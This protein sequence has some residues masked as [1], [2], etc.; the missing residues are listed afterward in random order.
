M[1][2]YVVQVAIF[3]ATYTFLVDSCGNCE[4]P[5]VGAGLLALLAAFLPSVIWVGM[6]DLSLAIRKHRKVARQ[7]QIDKRLMRQRGVLAKP[8]VSQPRLYRLRH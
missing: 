3:L 7:K 4:S 2:W 1:V 8:L 5:R 6:I